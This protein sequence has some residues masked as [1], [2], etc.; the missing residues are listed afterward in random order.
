VQLL[1]EIAERHGLVEKEPAPQIL[2]V[3]FGA[4]SLDFELRFWVNVITGNSGQVASDLRQM[5]AG[6][7]AEQGIVM[8]FPQCDMHLDAGRPLQVQVVPV[9]NA[10]PHENGVSE[11]PQPSNGPQAKE[12]ST[13]SAPEA[14]APRLP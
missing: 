5:I 9:V 4:S 1:T 13:D 10:S 3:N 2:F 11:S 7:F 12:Q 8:A 14:T 6:T